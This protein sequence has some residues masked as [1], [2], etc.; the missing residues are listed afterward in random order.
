MSES[1]TG[2]AVARRSTHLPHEAAEVVPPVAPPRP[3]L[4]HA[5]TDAEPSSPG[6]EPRRAKPSRPRLLIPLAAGVAGLIVG[7][8]LGSSITGAVTAAQHEAA[9]KAAIA[10]AEAAKSTF[11]ADAAQRCG[12]AGVVEI[13]DEG[14][15]MI[16]DGEGEDFGSGDVTFT[17]LDCLLDEVNVPA[18]VRSKMYATR[19][20]DGRQSGEWDDI[21]AS[22]SY[23]PDD[24]LDLILELVG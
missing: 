19:S 15:T 10:A 18:S 23:H 20:L 4:P 9:E 7:A 2:D 6:A 8:V 3:P 17:K 24:G 16:V 1:E 14:R 21:S 12:A 13:A 22:W 11:F 5:A